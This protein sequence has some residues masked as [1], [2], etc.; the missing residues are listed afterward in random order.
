[1]S[2]WERLAFSN[3]RSTTTNAND[4]L[5]T[6]TFT[7]KKYLHVECYYSFT[8]S[9]GSNP[10][11]S[12]NTDVSTSNYNFRKNT[13]QGSDT[14]NHTGDG[15]IINEFAGGD[16]RYYNRIDIIN[17]L[18]DEK[19]AIVRT[20]YAGEGATDDPH[21]KEFT[22]KWVNTSAQINKINIIMGAGSIDSGSTITV[23]G[24]D[25]GATSTF[26]APNG[27]IF[28]ES[29]TGKHYMFDGTSAWN[30]M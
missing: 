17:I 12:F 27:T 11:I 30:E 25:A 18:A 22:G 13:D 29:D 7:A 8:D 3:T 26:N 16:Q 10:R 14:T 15:A 21:W 1:M 5:S 9:G 28:E 6:G 19:Q 24:S 4:T 2:G 23:W 20:Y